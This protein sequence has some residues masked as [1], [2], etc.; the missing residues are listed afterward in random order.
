MGRWI[1]GAI[2]LAFLGGA[3]A[4]AQVVALGDSATKGYHLAESEAWPAKLEALLH[5]HGANVSVANEGVNGDTS[6]GMLSRLD[7]AV[8][9]GTRVVIFSCC[10]NDGK[11]AHH[12]VADHNGN[13]RTIVGQLR[14]RGIAVVYSGQ[15]HDQAGAATITCAAVRTIPE[16]LTTNPDP[17][18]STVLSAVDP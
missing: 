4:N 15:A 12:M 17:C 5:Q 10:G 1:G 2:L 18:S 6:D 14:A 3:Q 8:P 13:I 16:R 11:D 9:N 7:S